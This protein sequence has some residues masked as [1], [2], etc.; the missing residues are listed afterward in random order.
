MTQ[1]DVLVGM[2]CLDFIKTDTVMA[3]FQATAAMQ[4]PAKLHFYKT[5]LVHDAR[6]KI[7]QNAID[8]KMSHIM[9]IDSDMYFEPEAINKLLEHDKDIV[10]GLYYRKLPP[11]QPNITERKGDLLRFPRVWP[12][13]KPFKIFAAGTGFMLIKTSVFEKLEE[14][15]F[16][17]AS[18]GDQYMGE[19][20]YFCKKAGDAGFDVWVD[21]TIEIGH[22]GDYTYDRKD[23]DVYREGEPEENIE[24]LWDQDLQV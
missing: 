24:E 1:T 19:D 4:V 8:N 5:S 9:F 16:Y 18:L 20:I 14:P 6:N 17:F 12:K 2:P 21:P 22:I 23:Y 15:W 7:V 13:N 11:H 3:M 10:A